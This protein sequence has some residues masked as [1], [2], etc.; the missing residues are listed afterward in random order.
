MLELQLALD[1][2]TALRPGAHAALEEGKLR[3]GPMPV[4]MPRRRD[5]P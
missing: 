2:R 4:D 3:R 1:N 5:R